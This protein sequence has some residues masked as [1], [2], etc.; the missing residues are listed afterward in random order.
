MNASEVNVNANTLQGSLQ[1]DPEAVI[2]KDPDPEAV[3]MI[4]KD[5]KH[6]NVVCPSGYAHHYLRDGY[7]VKRAG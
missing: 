2:I 6:E 4:T 7:T 1:R 3:M 5:L